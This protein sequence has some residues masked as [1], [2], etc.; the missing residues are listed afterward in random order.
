[1]SDKE[2]SDAW[3]GGISRLQAQLAKLQSAC[4]ESDDYDAHHVMVTD[5]GRLYLS[6]RLKSISHE[7]AGD[8][9]AARAKLEGME[10]PELPKRRKELEEVEKAVDDVLNQ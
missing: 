10:G 2:K 4:K 7:I 6:L 1:M 5:Y 3:E 8:L 9:K